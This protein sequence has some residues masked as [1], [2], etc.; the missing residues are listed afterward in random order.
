MGLNGH[1]SDSF[2][3]DSLSEG[4][5]AYKQAHHKINKN[6]QWPK[7]LQ[8][9]S[10]IQKK[11]MCSLLMPVIETIH[12]FYPPPRVSCKFQVWYTVYTP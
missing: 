10:S 8:Y 9:N 4:L 7:M 2:Y 6:Q 12:N 5:F 3:T 1:L 11:S